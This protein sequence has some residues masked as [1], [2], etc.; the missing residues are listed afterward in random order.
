MPGTVAD[1]CYLI[2][3]FLEASQ[4]HGSANSILSFFG[5]SRGDLIDVGREIN[6]LG[7]GEKKEKRILIQEIE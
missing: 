3:E 1:K 4:G 2:A 7:S 5:G 6:K